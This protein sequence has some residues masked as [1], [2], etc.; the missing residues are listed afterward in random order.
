MPEFKFAGALMYGGAQDFS[1]GDK[2]GTGG[3]CKPELEPNFRLALQDKKCVLMMTPKNNL[4]WM[5][6]I[7]AGNT[8]AN[9]VRCQIWTL[10][11]NA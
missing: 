4:F 11:L 10:D 6:D 1:V 3:E 8:K 2:N 7:D 5:V 9:D